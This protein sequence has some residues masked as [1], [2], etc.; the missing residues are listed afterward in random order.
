M[1]IE[2]IIAEA[3][4]HFEKSLTH[5]KKE[6]GQIQAG[7]SNPALLDSIIIDLYGSPAPL[8][9]NASIS[10]PDPQSLAIQ[11][12]DKSLIAVIESA[13][14]KSELGLNPINDGTGIIRLNIP[15]LTEERRRDLVKVVH[16]K[17]EEAKVGIRKARQDAIHHIKALEGTSE[18]IV[19]NA[20]ENL[21]EEVTKA[22][23]EVESLTKQK[24]TDVMTV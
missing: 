19:K 17:S 22:N 21:Q 6:F 18:D 12:W 14:R 16:Q 20:E 23:K 24:E 9:N 4:E 13:I 2:F 7:Q 10:A 5:L 1:D 3:Q 8:K 11:P 15:P